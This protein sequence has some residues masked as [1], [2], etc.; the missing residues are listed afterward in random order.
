MTSTADLTHD[1]RGH[2][3]KVRAAVERGQRLIDEPRVRFVDERGR[4]Q[5][6][7]RPFAAHVRARQP[8]Q[9]L[10]DDGRQLVERGLVTA[11]PV[12]QQASDVAGRIAHDWAWHFTIVACGFNMIGREDV[13][14]GGRC[15]RGPQ[16]QMRLTPYGSSR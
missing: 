8:A 4:L 10:V 11:A 9:L 2:A 3:E 16:R 15:C 7:V 5:R 1:L 13:D 14:D 12:D 6:V